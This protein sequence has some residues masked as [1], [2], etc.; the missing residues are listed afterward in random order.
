VPSEL[1]SPRTKGSPIKPVYLFRTGKYPKEKLSG[2]KAGRA[3]GNRKK[4]HVP[5]LL[6][7]KVLIVAVR[8]DVLDCYVL[9]SVD[10][11]RPAL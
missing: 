6:F 5:D 9:R 8:R 7:L 1:P 2:D 11:T 3:K 10:G 4:K